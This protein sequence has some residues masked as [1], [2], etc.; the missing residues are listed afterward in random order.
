MPQNDPGSPTAC[1][2]EIFAFSLD[3]E[4]V[5]PL[6]LAESWLSQDERA[7]A[8]AFRFDVHRRR[9]IRGRGFL[10]GV[11]GRRLEREPAT[12]GFVAGPYGKPTLD[13]E[14]LQF[15]LSHSEDRA[16]LALADASGPGGVAAARGIGIDVERHD[17]RVD[18]DALARRC[19]REAEIRWMRSFPEDRRHLAFFRLWTA[20]EA[21][22]K[23]SGEGFQ[24]SPR[25]IEVGFAG[26][27]PD[28]YLAPAEPSARLACFGDGATVGAV[29]A[30]EP[31]RLSFGEV[32]QW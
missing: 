30:F 29:A 18:F 19:F 26:E 14:A 25:S 17:R 13:D 3:E 24:L 20:K 4:G 2:V 9:Y 22:M 28:R 27:W 15:N 23:A 12:L 5:L 21:R 11:L 16:A 1:A 7:R 31:L 6:D 8:A 10:R 32:P